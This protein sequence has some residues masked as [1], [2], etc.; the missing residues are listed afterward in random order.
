MVRYKSRF[1]GRYKT[2]AE[3]K[4][5]Y[6]LAKSGAPKADNTHP[7]RRY[8]PK[9]VYFMKNATT[10][11]FYVRPCVNGSKQL[12]GFFR[13]VREAEEAYRNFLTQGGLTS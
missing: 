5:A 1:Y 8:L 10:K 9:G 6:R 2:E 13:T 3:A 7:R 11:K 4:E 12:I